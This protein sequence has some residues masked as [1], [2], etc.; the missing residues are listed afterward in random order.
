MLA[1]RQETSG[2]CS[3]HLAQ[4]H[5]QLGNVLVPALRRLADSIAVADAH[6][7]EDASA[8]PVPYVH[9]MPFDR[10]RPPPVDSKAVPVAAAPAAELGAAVA[11]A[12]LKELQVAVLRASRTVHV[13]SGLPWGTVWQTRPA[14]EWLET[15][16]CS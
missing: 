15:Q 10:S 5:D 3:G 13:R 9:G 7:G 11:E 6:T 4:I 14:H 12:F 16:C 8:G 2:I 1:H